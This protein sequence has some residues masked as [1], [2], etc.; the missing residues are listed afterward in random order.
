MMPMRKMSVLYAALLVVISSGGNALAARDL[1]QNGMLSQ[2]KNGQPD[3]WKSEGYEKAPRATD[4]V[5][6]VGANGIGTLGIHNRLPNDSRYIQTLK[7]SPDTW[8]RIEGWLRSDNIGSDK[9]GIY[10]SVM[11]T[12][13]NSRDLRGTIGWQPVGLWV[14][15]GSLQTKLPIGCRLGGYS[16]LNTGRGWCTGISAIAAGEPADN[17]PFVYGERSASSGFGGR[18]GVQAI[19]VLVALGVLLLLWRYVL[20]PAKQIPK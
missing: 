13:F 20:P 15:T 1:V 16:S 9:V 17:A 14:K 19:A 6:Q 2:G 4:F 18:F 12:F 3:A 8:Y 7:V 10:L 5:W 11:G